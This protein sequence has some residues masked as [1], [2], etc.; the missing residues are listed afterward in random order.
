MLQRLNRFLEKWMFLV[1]PCCLAA[2]VL[3]PSVAGLGVP[4]VPL[5]FAFMTFIGGLKSSFRDIARCSA[6]PCPCWPAL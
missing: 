6:A 4:Y 2:G 1:T 3:F 5:V